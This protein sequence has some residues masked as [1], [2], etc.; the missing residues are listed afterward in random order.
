MAVKSFIVQ[1]PGA[2]EAAGFKPLTF[3]C[4]TWL[5]YHGAMKPNENVFA[6]ILKC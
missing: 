1:A 4:L 6:V 3:G 2:E 5:F